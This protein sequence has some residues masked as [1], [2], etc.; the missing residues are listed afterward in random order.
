MKELEEL[1]QKKVLDRLDYPI[2]LGS[3]YKLA[4]STYAALTLLSFKENSGNY[5]YDG[6]MLANQR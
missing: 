4:C 6:G 5:I 1:L 3:M 2:G